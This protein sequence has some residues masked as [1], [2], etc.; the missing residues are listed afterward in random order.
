[1]TILNYIGTMYELFR[2][3]GNHYNI[4]IDNHFGMT[5]IRNEWHMFSMEYVGETTKS[6]EKITQEGMQLHSLVICSRG[7]ANGQ[8]LA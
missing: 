1:M 7:K 2:E 8:R 4:N 3:D 5:T 6:Q